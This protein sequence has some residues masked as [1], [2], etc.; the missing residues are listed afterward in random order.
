MWR[1][2]ALEDRQSYRSTLESASYLR[3]RAINATTLETS[4]W[5]SIVDEN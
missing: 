4:E 5:M 3:V 1:P 2:V